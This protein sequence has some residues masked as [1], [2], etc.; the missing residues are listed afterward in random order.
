MCT[1]YYLQAIAINTA[2]LTLTGIAYASN[3]CSLF[4][5]DYSGIM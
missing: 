2:Y 3:H 1:H 4:E 5:K